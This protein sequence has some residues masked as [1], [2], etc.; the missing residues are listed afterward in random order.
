MAQFS[1]L[2]IMRT[3]VLIPRSGGG[4]EL[5]RYLGELH[6]MI[7][8]LAGS[9]MPLLWCTLMYMLILLIFGIFLTENAIEG[10]AGEAVEA[11]HVSAEWGTLNRSMYSLLIVMFGGKDWD[12]LFQTLEPLSWA[13]KAGFL[14]FVFFTYIAV[15]NTVTAIFIKCAFLKLEQD[16]EFVVQQEISEKNAYLASLHRVFNQ[17]D[18]DNS[19]W[20][21]FEELKNRL[22]DPSVA[23]YFRKLGVD[24]N[25]VDK[26]FVLM[27]EDGSGTITLPEFM[28]SCLR[29][30]GEA[31]S[32]DLELLHHD[33]KFLIH[34][35]MDVEHFPRNDLPLGPHLH[36]SRHQHGTGYVAN[37]AAMPAYSV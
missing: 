37:E 9:M 6:V 24:T 8:T 31:R 10:I 21:S 16:R 5:R 12:D 32:L 17:M 18:L 2:R 20:I 33:V 34:A 30:K 11:Q 36:G 35:I 28:A 23:A 26:M 7:R 3:L 19:G 14:S 15:V 27:D 29:L 13:S 1:F 22:K 25:Q 4:K